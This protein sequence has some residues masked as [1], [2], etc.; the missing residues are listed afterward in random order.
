[1]LDTCPKLAQFSRQF[2][3]QSILG[4]KAGNVN[5]LRWINGTAQN[6]VIVRVYNIYYLSAYFLFRVEFGIKNFQN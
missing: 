3:R 2:Q 4:L 1:M 5:V 6:L